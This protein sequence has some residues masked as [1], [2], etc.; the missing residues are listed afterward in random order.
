MISSALRIAFP[1]A[2]AVVLP[3]LAQAADAPKPV[4]ILSNWFA[5]PDQAGYW[6]AQ[7]DKLG[8][9][10]G[11]EISVLQG[12]PKIQTIPQV[13]SGQAEF[14]IGNADDVLLARL[15]GAPVRAVFAHLDYVPYTLVY[16]ADPAVKSIA[17]LQG[18]TF[19]VNIGNAYWEWTKKQYKLT[20]TREIP[21]SGDL[22]LFRNDPKMVQQGYS[23][24]LPARMAAAGVQVQQV[25]LASLGYRPYDVLFTTDDMIRKNPALVKATI[26][27]LQ[28]GW[29]N[30]V[31][32]PS[33]LKPLITGMNK[34]MTPEIYDA[35]NKEMIETLISHDLGRIGCMTDARWSEL[36]GQLRSVNFLP[37]NFD[38][39]QGYDRT[40]VPGCN[41]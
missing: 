29:A 32:N 4:R 8:K 23:L 33:G 9:E 5:Q 7:Q 28:K 38:A 19:A 13:A 17:D 27:A 26:A 34:Q 1:L 22:S 14:G 30:Y 12:G 20:G 41:P 21:V 6:Q 3:L 39:K 35:A 18:R 10:A 11:I 16:H 25:T 15:R 31:R 40:L 37:A 36:A 2:L 24:F